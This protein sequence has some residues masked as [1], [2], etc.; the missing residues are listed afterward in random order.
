M[1]Y[2]TNIWFNPALNA[3]R[4]AGELT[5]ADNV[6]IAVATY[7]AVLFPT[8]KTYIGNRISGADPP[9]IEV[10]LYQ[11]SN[12]KRLANTDEFTFGVEITYSPENS[13]DRSEIS[14]AIFL[15]LQGLDT[16]SS[17]IGTFR[18]T[19]KNSDMTDCLGHVTANVTAWEIQ[20]DTSPI[21]Q[22]AE[23]EVIK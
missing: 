1:A 21:I 8:M 4:K 19:D 22:K 9:E 7:T 18:C 17:G 20:P 5:L 16:V 3:R 12:S 10:N 6:L 23:S 13:F 15:I 11:Q 2:P 14:H